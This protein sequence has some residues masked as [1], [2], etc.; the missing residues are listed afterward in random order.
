MLDEKVVAWGGSEYWAHHNC[1]TG[2]TTYSPVWIESQNRRLMIK[3]MSFSGTLARLR[4]EGRSEDY[5]AG[6]VEGA[7]VSGLEYP[8]CEN[9]CGTG[10]VCENHPDIPW[11][12]MTDEPI[13][14]CGCGAGMNCRD[15]QG[16]GYIM[17]DEQHNKDQ[18]R[19]I[20]QWALDKVFATRGNQPAEDAIKEAG[21]LADWVL[22][23]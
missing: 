1:A 10:T 3:G 9:C 4:S 17:T 18:E 6:Y 12:Y 5:I 16:K 14:T 23:R 7:K 15:C 19:Y 21:K 22:A 11:E 13:E 20:R 2:V 8:K